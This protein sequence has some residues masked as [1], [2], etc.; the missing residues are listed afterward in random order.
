MRR[1]DF[2][3]I[4][5]G[6]ALAWPRAA[7]AD[8]VRTV[9]VLMQGSET[10]STNAHLFDALRR[11]LADLGWREGVNLKIELRW[12]HNE[13]ARARA[14]AQELV[15]LNPDLI[16]APATSIAPV[17]EATQSIPIVFL[18]IADPVGQGVVSSLAHPGGNL[19]GFAYMEFSTGGKLVELLKEI[20]PDTTRLLALLDANG[21]TS[22]PQWWRSI[23][24]AA[25]VMSIEPQ[26]AAINAADEIDTAIHAFAQAQKG[27][28]VVPGQSLFVAH[29]ARLVAAAAQ[30]R[31]PAVYG[32]API[33]TAGGLMSYAPDAVDQFMRAASYVDR[34]LKGDRPGDLPV[35]QPTKFEL[36]I[37][38]K[39]AKTLGIDIPGSILA[40]AD[41]VIE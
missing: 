41:E 29:A 26:Q 8:R 14:Y 13:A 21:T 15:S 2:M 24:D 10:N 12:A 11:S 25:R 34:I 32:A 31:L 36:I 5:G 33:A 9:A 39:T 20:A 38:L 17:R 28:I 6:A 16:V 35:Q 30:E 1:R 22:T 4:L 18:L 7:R 3:T 19:T 40:Q 23:E 37:N 27:G